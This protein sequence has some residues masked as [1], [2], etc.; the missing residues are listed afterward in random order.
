MEEE[1]NNWKTADGNEKF[2]LAVFLYAN[3]AVRIY[4]LF[5]KMNDILKYKFQNMQET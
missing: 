3:K 1:S 4:G 5:E 2:L